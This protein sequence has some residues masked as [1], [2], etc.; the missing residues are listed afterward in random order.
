MLFDSSRESS[1]PSLDDSG[2]SVRN[3]AALPIVRLSPTDPG[4]PPRLAFTEADSQCDCACRMVESDEPV[5]LQ[6]PISFYLELTPLCNNRCHACGNVFVKQGSDRKLRGLGSPLSAEGWEQIMAKILPYTH[7]LKLTGGEPTLHPDF[8]TIV[9]LVANHK[10]P[11]TLLSNGRW[12]RPERLVQLLKRVPTLQ[13]LLLS[14]HG[15]SPARHEAFTGVTGSFSETLSSI[16]MARE[17][18][19]PV[20]LSCVITHHNWLQ[21]TEMAEMARGLGADGVVFNRYLGHDVAG[22]TASAEELRSAVNTITGL[23]AAGHA[24]K[25]GN[26]LPQCFAHTGQAGCLAGLA[27]F[28]IDPW[29]KVRPCNHAP[30]VAG[31]LLQQS[32]EEIWHSPHMARWRSFVPSQC[33]DCSLAASCQGGCRAQA[34]IL[35]RDAD[36]L[37]DGPF[38][39]ATMLPPT[40][41]TF[42]AEAR[43]MGSYVSRAE[44]F[45]AVLVSGNRLYPVDRDMQGV[46]DMLNGQFTLEQIDAAHG[47]DGL[48]LVGS[49]FQHG[50]LQ[51]VE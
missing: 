41:L 17:A 14:L 9:E 44:A 1:A 25:L 50:M 27:F 42:Y 10:I 2:N 29:G 51:F 32:V 3:P 16:R 21:V 33:T 40:E 11:F 6:T 7:R 49:L 15:P 31:D 43:P 30:T 20:S 13:G 36:P 38:R 24:V 19:L 45:G 4:F 35:G 22:L 8:D 26:C 28:T 12:R 39:P 5:L 46:L 37:I 34:L 18:G 47:A 23:R 48:S